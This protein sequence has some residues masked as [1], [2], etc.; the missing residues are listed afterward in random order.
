MVS[1][2]PVAAEARRELPGYRSPPPV[3]ISVYVVVPSLSETG[4][5]SVN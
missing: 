1:E 2:V 4:V 3:S 5:A